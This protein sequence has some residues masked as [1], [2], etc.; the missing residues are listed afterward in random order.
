MTKPTCKLLGQ[1]GNI[2]NLIAITSMT[3][4]KAGEPSKAL[5][6]NKRVMVCGSYDEALRIIGEYVEI[7]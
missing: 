7:V 4:K 6:M 1:N 2:I 3:L 5:E